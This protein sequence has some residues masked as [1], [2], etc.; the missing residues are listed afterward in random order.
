MRRKPVTDHLALESA[1]L[2]PPTLLGSPALLQET[3]ILA[4]GHLTG[5]ES[6][7]WKKRICTPE[8]LSLA[9]FHRHSSGR[10]DDG[11]SPRLSTEKLCY[12]Q[13]KKKSPGPPL[14][15]RNFLRLNFLNLFSENLR[16]EKPGGTSNR[17][18]GGLL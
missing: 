12:S 9:L 8:A 18:L 15:E 17:R 16:K 14:K 11:D 2:P 13:R 7:V 5:F 10:N 6:C 4:A 1:V 3:I